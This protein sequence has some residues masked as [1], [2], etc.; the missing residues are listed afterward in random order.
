M[1]DAPNQPSF[2]YRGGDM[3]KHAPFQQQNTRM[4]GFFIEG[5]RDKLQACIDRDLNAV[6]NGK[7]NFKPLSDYVMLTF[8]DIQKC[9]S[10]NPI[11]INK[12][13]GVE[14]DVCFWVP[15][16]NIVIKDGIEKLDSVYWYTPL[17]LGEQP[18]RHGQWP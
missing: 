12:G 2:I 10:S 4:Y 3:L 8:A 13:W 7:Y 6:A 9:Y 17:Y 15:V 1:T 14:I 11:D 16:A 5:Q 18:Y